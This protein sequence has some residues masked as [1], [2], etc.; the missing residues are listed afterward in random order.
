[1][2]GFIILPLFLINIALFSNQHCLECH[3]KVVILPEA[4]GKIKCTGCHGGIER[5]PHPKKLPDAGCGQ[6]HAEEQASYEKGAH[7]YSLRQGNKAAPR[8]QDCHGEHEILPVEYSSSPVNRRNIPETCGKCHK[9]PLFA[10]KHGIPIRNPYELYSKSQHFKALKQG[11]MD[12]AVCTDCHGVHGILNSSQPDAP[13]FRRNIPETCSRCHKD[14]FEAFTRSIHWKAFIKG[15]TDAALCTDCHG[16]HAILSP[17]DTGSS[18]FP[19]EIPSTCISCHGDVRLTSRYGL[20]ARRLET[21]RAS[22]H[23]IVLKEGELTAAH[24]ASCHGSH[25]ILPSSDT[26]ASTNPQNLI[27][28]CGKCHP[29][30]SANFVRGRIHVEPKKSVSPGVFYVRIFYTIFIGSLLFFFILHIIFDVRKRF[31]K[32]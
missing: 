24:C 15:N 18:V 20:P 1:M 11:N 31:R 8:C 14:E 12:A 2:F 5:L 25:L 22:Y 3:K 28:T 23:G 26:L 17:S 21:Y 29:G 4:H 19:T 27:E 16:E 10:E 9:E 13:I 32:V 30:A 6:C 7:G